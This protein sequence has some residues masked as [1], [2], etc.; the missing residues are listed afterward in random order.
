MIFVLRPWKSADSD[1]RRSA[2]WDKGLLTE[3]GASLLIPVVVV[4]TSGQQLQLSGSMTAHWNEA[5]ARHGELAGSG[6][7]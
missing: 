6:R 2:M 5:A 4:Q 3:S 7:P 1:C